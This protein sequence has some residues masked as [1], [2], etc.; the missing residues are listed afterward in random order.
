MPQQQQQQQQVPPAWGN[1]P[2]PV[3]PPQQQQQP[4]MQQPVPLQATFDFTKGSFPLPE[5]P[6]A[7]Q[8]KVEKKKDPFEDLFQ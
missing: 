2:A 4:V 3:P 8:P 6:V 5:A 7:V 1:G